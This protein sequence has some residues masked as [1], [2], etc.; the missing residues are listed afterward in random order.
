MTVLHL[1]WVSR[2][3][4]LARND[5]GS[6]SN[7]SKDNSLGDKRPVISTVVEKSNTQILR[8]LNG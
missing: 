7:D 1:A 4:L 6:G 8:I 2:L 5:K 3:A